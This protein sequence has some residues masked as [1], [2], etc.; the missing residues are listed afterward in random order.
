MVKLLLKE[1]TDID[2]KDAREWTEMNWAASKGHGDQWTSAVNILLLNK[3]NVHA[4][5]ESEVTALH[6]AAGNGHTK[7]VS[8]LLDRGANTHAKNADETTAL[9][10]AAVKGCTDVVR[11]LLDKAT[12]RHEGGHWHGGRGADEDADA[13]IVREEMKFV[14]AKDRSGHTALHLA[15]RESKAEIVRLLLQHNAVYKADAKGA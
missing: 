9:H 12:T 15:V 14:N 6:W 1:S 8:A 10:W 3:A 13:D 7:T 2:R 5:D 4:K 11:V